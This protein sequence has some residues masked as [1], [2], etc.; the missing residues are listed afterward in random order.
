VA[1]RGGGQASV[2]V[3]VGYVAGPVRGMPIALASPVGAAA[4]LGGVDFS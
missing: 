1:L 2:E 3:G 4:R